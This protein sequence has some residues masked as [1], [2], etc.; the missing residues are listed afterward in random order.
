MHRQA[1][2][3]SIA[4]AIALAVL[5]VGVVQAKGPTRESDRYTDRFADDFILD[6]CGIDTMTT[7]IDHWTFKEYPDGSATFHSTRTFI[8]DDPRIPIEKG[9]ATSFIA[10]D[11][12]R[13]VVGSP[14]QLIEQNGGGVTLLDA[15]WIELDASDTPVAGR[16]PHPSFE[17]DLAAVYC[18]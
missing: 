8:P 2:V 1:L 15:G 14:I 3:R 9:A 16:G 7:L 17:V 4:L 11:G 13:R 5:A 12:S 18:P 6:L 10:P